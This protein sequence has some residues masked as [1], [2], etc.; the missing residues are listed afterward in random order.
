VVH[1]L[2]PCQNRLCEC[3]GRSNTGQ[4]VADTATTCFPVAATVG[5][6]R[7]RRC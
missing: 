3:A 7:K 5:R 6:F 1:H 2:L 4:K